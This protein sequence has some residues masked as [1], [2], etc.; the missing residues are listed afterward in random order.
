MRSATTAISR[1]A[2]PLTLLVAAVTGSGPMVTSASAAQFGS[3]V[4]KPG[5]AQQY[6]IGST[7]LNLR[8]CNDL[9]SAGSLSAAI[10]D[11]DPYLLTPGECTENSGDKI[12]VQNRSDGDVA[13]VYRPFDNIDGG[14]NH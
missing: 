9:G 4:L 10:G 12:L 7:Y 14:V 13:G 8:V 1:S 6:Q 2:L 3:F 11:H 5:A